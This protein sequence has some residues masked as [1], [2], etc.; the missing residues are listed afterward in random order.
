MWGADGRPGAPRCRRTGALLAWSPT[1]RVALQPYVIASQAMPKV[2][3]APIFVLWFGFGM[4][5]RWS[6]PP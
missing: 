4:D 5:R 1:I 6:S 2:A 3:L